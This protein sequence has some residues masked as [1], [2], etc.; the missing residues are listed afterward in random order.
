MVLP[1]QDNA[2]VEVQDEAQRVCVVTSMHYIHACVLM[3]VSCLRM[4][5]TMILGVPTVR[6]VVIPIGVAVD[7]RSNAKGPPQKQQQQHQQQRHQQRHQHQHQHQHRYRHRHRQ[8][9]L[10]LQPQRQRQQQ[11]LLPLSC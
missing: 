7:F 11:L 4:I 8:P 5:F 1:V 3:Y 2:T 10:Q 6:I 9:Q